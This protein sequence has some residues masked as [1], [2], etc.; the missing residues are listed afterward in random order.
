MLHLKR[1]NKSY[2]SGASRI[3]VLRELGPDAPAGLF[4]AIVRRSSA[5]KS[6]LLNIL[7]R[8]NHPR[9]RALRP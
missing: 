8:L 7:G 6:T 5:G 1:V 9:Q 3:P 4:A 2:A